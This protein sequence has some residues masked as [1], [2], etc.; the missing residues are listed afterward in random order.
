VNKYV[1]Y[2][3][4]AVEADTFEQA[5]RSAKW[6]GWR[7]NYGAGDTVPQDQGGCNLGKVEVIA[8]EK[9]ELP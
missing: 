4:V 1:I 7:S 6:V 2:V 9:D 8:V 3:A 5:A